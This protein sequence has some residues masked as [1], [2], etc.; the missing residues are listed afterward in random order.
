MP[1]SVKLPPAAPAIMMMR[2]LLLFPA[3]VDPL[4]MMVIGDVTTGRPFAPAV[5]L[6]ADV[7]EYVQPGARMM[8]PPPLAFALLTAPI[9]PAAP[10]PAPEQGTMLTLEARAVAP[11]KKPPTAATATTADKLACLVRARTI[12]D[13]LLPA[14]K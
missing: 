11:P 3:I 14:A 4:P 7:S 6:F 12:P 1:S 5:M 9:S 13:S 10:P 8:I 2:K